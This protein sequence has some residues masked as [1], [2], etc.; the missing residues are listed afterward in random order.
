MEAIK[1]GHATL[2]VGPDAM[3]QGRGDGG[4][5]ELRVSTL[6]SLAN[7]KQ[8]AVLRSARIPAVSLDR[9]CAI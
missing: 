1:V 8:T 6:R 4:P 3:T 5:T 2:T 7:V 9:V